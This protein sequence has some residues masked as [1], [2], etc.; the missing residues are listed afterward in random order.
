MAKYKFLIVDDS[1]F[2]R[3]HIRGFLESKGHQVGAEAAN[4]DEAVALYKSKKPDLTTMDL[5]MPDRSGLEAIKEIQAF[6]PKARF[7]IVSAVD[8]KLIHDEY[9]AWKFCEYVGKPP[10]WGK[11]D[12]AIDHLMESNKPKK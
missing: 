7:I 11:L 10:E 9:S 2:T 1:M 12:V 5:N 3:M 6:D 8:Q 4:A